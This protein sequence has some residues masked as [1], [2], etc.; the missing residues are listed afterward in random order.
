MRSPIRARRRSCVLALLVCLCIPT[1][2]AADDPPRRRP[3]SACTRFDQRASG[4]DAVDLVVANRCAIPVDCSVTWTV[5][6]AP[7]SPKRRSTKREGAAFR[8]EPTTSQTTTASAA[9]CGGDG[10]QITAI[11]WS[12]A[13]ARD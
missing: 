11:T 10:W 5:T 1:L 13:P 3:V 8:L 12:C 2:A 4:E 6:C 7:E 9:R